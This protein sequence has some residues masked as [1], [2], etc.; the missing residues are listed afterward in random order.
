MRAALVLLLG[1]AACADLHHLSTGECGNKV[2]E[3]GEDCDTNSDACVACH[4]I[5]QTSDECPLDGTCGE[6]T[7]P[8]GRNWKC[9]RMLLE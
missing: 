7:A 8:P 5:C 9:S 4:W 3:D 2:L 1:L 6:V